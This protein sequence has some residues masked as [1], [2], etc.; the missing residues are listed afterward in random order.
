MV[1]ESDVQREEEEEEEKA[2]QVSKE[3][4]ASSSTPLEVS[5]TE[6]EGSIK[7]NAHPPFNKQTIHNDDDLLS[8]SKFGGVVPCLSERASTNRRNE[9][10]AR[11]KA[12]MRLAMMLS[13]NQILEPHARLRGPMRREGKALSSTPTEAATETDWSGKKKIVK[14]S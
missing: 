13:W 10:C 7:E 4:N 8:K 14:P 11:S 5:A 12:V 1:M 2:K 9:I 6:S 3:G